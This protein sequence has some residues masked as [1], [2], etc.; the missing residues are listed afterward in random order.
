MSHILE[1]VVSLIVKLLRHRLLRMDDEIRLMTLE[2]THV[3]KSFFVL[4][5]SVI[6]LVASFALLILKIVLLIR[7]VLLQ[8]LE[9]FKHR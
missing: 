3:R 8:S 2:Q 6:C 4:I 5:N 7:F 9:H 1:N